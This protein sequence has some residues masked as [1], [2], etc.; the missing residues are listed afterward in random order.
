MRGADAALGMDAADGASRRESSE[1]ERAVQGALRRGYPDEAL[2]RAGFDA[3]LSELA[4][5]RDVELGRALVF[6]A[7]R[8]APADALSRLWALVPPAHADILARGL[9]G[10]SGALALSMLPPPLIPLLTGQH[11][12]LGAASVVS[13]FRL[14][15]SAVAPIA[16]AGLL[17]SSSLD[18]Q[19]AGA[20][21]LAS[22][23]VPFPDAS[24]IEV[25]PATVVPA[26]VRSLAAR[27]DSPSAL[28]VALLRMTANRAAVAPRL[29]GNAWRAVRDGAA[30][31]GRPDLRAE[32]MAG[33]LRASEASGLPALTL[34]HL[35]CE[36]AVVLDKL[37]GP[38]AATRTCASG[39]E[40]WVSLMSQAAVLGAW[41]AGAPGM[42]ASG[43]SQI[44]QQA[45]GDPRVL[46]A[47]ASAAVE[48]DGPAGT[49]L[50]RQLAGERDAGIL[51]ALLEGLVLHVQHARA[52]PPQTRAALLRAPF[53]LPESVSIEARIQSI[54]LARM[55]GAAEMISRAHDSPIG[56]IRQALQ[57][58][59][60][61][62]PA[63]PAPATSPVR[64]ILVRLYTD[65]GSLD[66]ELRPDA[67]PRAVEQVLSAIRARRYDG[68]TFHRVVPGFVVQGADPRGDGYGGTEHFVPTEISLHP[69]DRGAVGIPLAGLDTGGIQLF[70][71]LAPAPHLDGRYP[72]IGR[73]VRGMDV[74]DGIL[75]GDHIQRVEIL[76]S[77]G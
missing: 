74:V 64:P 54:R 47:V 43:L 22:P 59:A 7:A 31:L 25:V 19:L 10:R 17:T 77:H 40:N 6:S 67:A 36:N 12:D 45:A 69:F 24:L 27:S 18:D 21:I 75:I 23:G 32:L 15:I 35:R 68:L 71:T 48:I 46:E 29:W 70:I 56:A 57:P 42:R 28:W 33:V 39:A 51:A 16:P 4:A 3:L 14:D 72:W 41:G 13:R 58:D 9:A 20:R 8:R 55:L 44:I 66:L 5:A 50:V 49:R 38:P 73:V 37:R 62:Y 26:L 34:A 65:A 2:D 30:G 63:I 61:V 60:A 76:E 11:P 1:G 53:D 52:L